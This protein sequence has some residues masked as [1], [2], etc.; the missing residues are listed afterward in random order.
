ME[1]YTSNSHSSKRLKDELD[2]KQIEPVVKTPVKKRKRTEARKLLDLFI[3][4]D[5]ED[6]SNYILMDVLIPGIK[7]TIIDI[8]KM[9]FF[10]SRG[11]ANNSTASKISYRRISEGRYSENQYEPRTRMGYDYDDIILDNR[12]EAEEV[13]SRMDELISVY[14][15]ASVADFYDLVGVSGNYTDNKYGWTDIRNATV[16]RVRDG[17]VIKFPKALPLS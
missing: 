9:L 12:G 10:G 5:R 1:E 3:A 11:T 2:K 17:Y 7:N 16:V 8:I 15:L 6:V 14:G 4:E 13:L